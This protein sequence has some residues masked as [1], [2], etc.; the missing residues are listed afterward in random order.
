[1]SRIAI[2][3]MWLCLFTPSQVLWVMRWL[4]STYALAERGAGTRCSFQAAAPL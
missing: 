2:N 3:A 1:V 4:V